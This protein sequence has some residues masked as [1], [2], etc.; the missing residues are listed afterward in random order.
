LIGELDNVKKENVQ[1]KE[2]VKAVTAE[3]E[4]KEF[5]AKHKAIKETLQTQKKESHDEI[6]TTIGKHTIIID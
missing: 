6:N 5:E 2:E 1:L 3:G 4:S